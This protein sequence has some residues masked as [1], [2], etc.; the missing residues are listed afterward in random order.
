M[1]LSVPEEPLS[2]KPGLQCWLSKGG[3][4]SVQVLFNGIE[5]VM[6]PTL[7]VRSGGTNPQKGPHLAPL[8]LGLNGLQNPPSR[9]N[10]P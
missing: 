4:S 3:S 9:L 10:D 5:A 2:F 1:K 7:I 6:V 8:A